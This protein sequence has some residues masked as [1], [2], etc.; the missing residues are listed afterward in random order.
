MR[1][2]PSPR[3]ERD[4]AARKGWTLD[5]RQK[6]IPGDVGRDGDVPGLAQIHSSAAPTKKPIPQRRART[7][8]LFKAAEFYPNALAI[9]KNSDEGIWIGQQ[10]L[11]C[12]Q[13]AVSGVPGARTVWLMD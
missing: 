10:K 2:S 9:P 12:I 4:E 11:K 6:T 3:L 5:N 1:D 13:A 8:K 7:T